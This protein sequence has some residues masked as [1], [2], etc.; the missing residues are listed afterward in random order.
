[1]SGLIQFSLVL[2][3]ILKNEQNLD[4]LLAFDKLALFPEKRDEVPVVLDAITEIQD[5]RQ[6]I[7]E[8]I[9]EGMESMLLDYQQKFFDICEGLISELEEDD[10]PG[11]MEG[12][13]VAK[14]AG[15]QDD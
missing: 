15:L 1:M 12:V 6:R 9:S 7:P 2:D 5:W 8:Q 3:S 11:A 14:D 10:L 4:T 13:V